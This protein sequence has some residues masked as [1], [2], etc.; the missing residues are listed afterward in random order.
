[1]VTTRECGLVCER[2]LVAP[3][4]LGPCPL[5]LQ[6]AESSVGFFVVTQ[7]LHCVARTT[8]R[9]GISTSQT[10][11]RPP[12]QQAIVRRWIVTRGVPVD[13]SVTPLFAQHALQA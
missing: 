3:Q 1:M 4:L 5:T 9:M 10:T 7:D 2:S 13:L 8:V 11:R 6:P 12:I